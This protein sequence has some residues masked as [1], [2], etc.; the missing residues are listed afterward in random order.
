MVLAGA[1]TLVVVAVST[2]RRPRP[3]AQTALW[4]RAEPQPTTATAARGPVNDVDLI[5]AV[6]GTA[7]D[8]G[9]VL[10]GPAERVYVREP[11]TRHDVRKTST[12]EADAVHQLLGS[13]HFTIGGNHTVRT[14]DRREGPARSVLVTKTARATVNRWAALHPLR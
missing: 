6:I 7:V 10:I 1:Y 5:R 3:P 14:P 12:Y 9:Y 2:R 8:P 4:G 11:G 13:G